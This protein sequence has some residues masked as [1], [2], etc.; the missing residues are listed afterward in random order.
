LGFD[1]RCETY[2]YNRGLSTRERDREKEKERERER[3]ERVTKAIPDEI[4][5]CP[6]EIT[7]QSSRLLF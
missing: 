7:V 4:S 1:E 2:E 3:K 6:F 5:F